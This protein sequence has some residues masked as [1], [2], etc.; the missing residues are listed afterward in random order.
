M[1][2]QVREFFAQRRVLEVE[3]PLA[4]LHTVTDPNIE[5][6]SFA[7]RSNQRYLQTSPEYAMKRLLAAGASDIYQIC[8]CF[9]QG[10]QGDLHNPEFTMIEWYRLGQSIE[11][12]MQETVELITQ[13]L[14]AF[15]L[16]K[17][18]EY[19]TYADL[20]SQSLGVSFADLA[21]NDIDQICTQHGLQSVRK[22]SLAQ[23]IDFIFSHV[24][25]A[26]LNSNAITCVY[27][28]PA[29]QA[30]LAR[31]NPDDDSVAD[32][33]E[34]FDAFPKL[35]NSIEAPTASLFG[36]EIRLVLASFSVRILL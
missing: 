15:E 13:V 29:E 19:V 10:E 30:A 26:K 4:C 21:E 23:K 14:K 3:T 31:L 24:I 22:F 17:Q 7:D 33:F 12:I 6:Y 32:R 25:A 34:A 1:L 9:R 35:Y 16:S 2:A 20:F 36:V 27:H 8:K 28:Y 11:Q 18:V 5:S